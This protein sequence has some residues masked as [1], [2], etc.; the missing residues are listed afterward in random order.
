MA[1]SF[2]IVTGNIFSIKVLKLK[3]NIRLQ[4]DQENNVGFQ[5]EYGVLSRY[6]IPHHR[7]GEKILQE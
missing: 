7:I 5:T 3:A 4:R 1:K 2:I 6:L